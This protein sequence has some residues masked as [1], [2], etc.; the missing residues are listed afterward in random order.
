[1]DILIRSIDVA[2][3]KEIERKAKDIR[4]KIGTE[5]S[6]N[7]YIKM[8]IQNDCEFQ[9]TKLKEDKFDRVVDNLNYT[10]TN[11][12]ETLQEFI[13]SNNRLFH[14]MVSGIDMLDDEWRD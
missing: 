1:M 10:L 5:F 7:D 2:Y 11:Q 13:D 9:L 6:R 14:F 3:A 4:N 12:S 8:L